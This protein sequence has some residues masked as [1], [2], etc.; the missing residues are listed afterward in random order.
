KPRGKLAPQSTYSGTF[1][2]GA[3]ARDGSAL[4]QEIT[5][6]FRTVDSLLVGQVFP[7]GGAEEVATDTAVTVIFNK[8]VVP[9]KIKEEQASLPQPLLFTPEVAG[10]GEWI[11]SSVYVFQP[12]TRLRSA[13]HYRVRV[14]QGLVDTTGIPMQGG[15]EWQFGTESPQV[16]AYSLVNGEQ[17]PT[18]LVRNVLLDQ[19]FEFT[20]SQPMDPESVGGAL[21]LA[22]R[23]T[24]KPVALKLSW[25][26]ER[27]LL[28][29]K[30]VQRLEIASF[31]DL[32]L[33]DTAAAED[34]G[35][36][37]EGKTIKL[38]TVPQP[39]IVGVS[40]GPDSTQDHFSALLSITFAS[41]MKLSSLAGRVQITP[42]PKSTN[43]Y[44]NE[45]DRQ[46][47]IYGLDPS[48]EYVVR[49]LP[50]MQDIYGNAIRTEYSFSFKTAR[51]DPSATMLLPYPAMVYREKGKQ[52]LYFQYT[53][54]TSLS[55]TVYSMSFEEFSGMLRADKARESFAPGSRKP[56]L[57]WRLEAPVEEN[58]FNRL[59]L[60][61]DEQGAHLSPG[62]YF[63]GLQAEPFQTEY[64]Y[65]QA[66]YFIVAS[67][68]I[69][70]KTTD[71]E[72]L[73][74]VVDL[75][76]GKP[77]PGEDVTFYDEKLRPLGS[78][79]TDGDGLAYLDKIAK[80]VYAQAGKAGR[81]AFAS[82][83]WGSGMSAGEF[84][85]WTGYYGPTSGSF[86]Y[87]YTDRPLYRPGQE[88]HFK[89]IL[90]LDDDLHYS[91]PTERP[92]QV[93]IT[94][95]E[96]EVY[97]KTLDVSE[98]GSFEDVF[99]IAE[100]A[101][102][103]SY[104][105]QVGYK[106]D[107]PFG[108]VSFRVAEYR[109]PQF[110]LTASAAAS[111]VLVGADIPFKLQADYY[112]G[113]SLGG[114]E[115]SWFTEAAPYSFQP[116]E[117]YWQFSFTDY[118]FD[119]YRSQAA[120][121]AGGLLDTGTGMTDETGAFSV[122]QPATLSKDNV[123]R[124]ITFYANVTDVAGNLVGGN[125]SVIVHQSRVYAGIRPVQYLGV[126]GK[127]LPFELVALDWSSNPQAGMTVNVDIMKEE[128]F[129]VQKQDKFGRL[130]WE[131]TLKESR[132]KRY[133]DVV[134]GADGLA[135]ISFVPPAGGQY[136]AIVTVRD[137]GGHSHRASVGV[138]VASAEYIPWRQT[139]DR[140]FDLVTDKES[141]SPGE[142]AQVLIASPFEGEV[143]ALISYERGHIYERKVVLL[144]ENSTIYELP[145]T[146][147]MAPGVYL[148]V[149]VVRGAGDGR[150]DFKT[151]VTQLK[152]DTSQQALTVKV[153][154]DAQTAQPQGKVTY[155][156]QTSDASGKPVQAEVSLALVDK[157]VLALAPAN[158]GP[159]L[160]AF[161]RHRALAVA[162][163]V[164]IVLDAESFNAA[165]EAPADGQ[166][167]GS[168]G[169]GKG[170]GDLGVIDV[171]QEFKD[172]A[173]WR[174]VL[175]TGPEGSAQ[176]T[177]ELPDNLTTWQMDARAATLDSRFGQATSELVS[178]KPLFV[179]L[180]APRFFVVRDAARVGATIHNNTDAPQRVSV[181]LDA[182][183]VQ[184][185]SEGTQ[186]LEVGA[187]QQAYVTWDLVVKP[188]ASRVDLL[189]QASAGK[190]Q[191]STRPTLG[192]LPG[193]GI[194][195]HAYH[196]RETVGTA[197]ILQE[198]GSITE[199]VQL[200][201]AL[202]GSDA[203]LSVDLSPSLAASMV[204]GLTYLEDYP[205][206]CIEQTISRFL[207][208]VIASR[209]L[210]LAGQP[211]PLGE[212]LE[213][214]IAQALQRINASQNADG[215]WGWWGEQ[216]SHPL[217]T[218]YVVLGLVEAQKAGHPVSLQVLERGVE[219]LLKNVPALHDNSAWYE[220][221]QEAFIVYVLAR[222]G[223]SMDQQAAMLFQHKDALSIYG[224]AYLAH[225]IFIKDGQD[226]RLPALLA[227]I[228]G[229]A[230]L[231]A[232]GVH[233]QEKDV[234][235]W[236]WNTDTRTTA[237]VLNMLTEVDPKS[238]LTA[239]AVR[240]LMAHRESAHWAS[241]QETAWVLM[242]LTNWLSVS[243]EFETDYQYA[244]GLNG[245]LLKQGSASR[246]NL[247]EAV[248]VRQALSE[249]AN[250]LVFTRGEGKGN[251]YYSAYLDV[252]LPV[253][254]VHALDQ[255]ILLSRQYYALDDL[256][257]PVTSIQKGELVQARVTIVVPESLH[258]VVV[259]DPLPAGLEAVD[260]SL[261]TGAQVPDKYSRDD[262]VRKGWGWWYFSHV[263]IR[264]E[265]VELSAD[266]LPAGTYVFTYLARA[267][268]VGT[269]QVIPV[270]AEE[271]YFPDV[272]GRG[273][274]SVF[275]VKP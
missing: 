239:N 173:Y 112:S 129:S 33:T 103:G 107:E 71:T 80:P 104:D 35:R 83:E 209:A 66:A 275:T 183:G 46:Y 97:N 53:N 234:D 245:D 62:Y 133:P 76:T 172:T 51:L 261:L 131:S 121:P 75:E 189:A 135:R 7:A 139:N 238:P 137:Q 228:S 26:D 101:Q 240:W 60:N 244:V 43:T 231:S 232:A 270:S 212:D 74:W 271:F 45:Y 248:S 124:R 153:T 57:E 23:E 162:T 249:A 64:R 138:W 70:L 154:P 242:A 219:F 180:Q 237:I 21:S 89:G 253:D 141:Y 3:A 88:V 226:K 190:Y 269:F 151:G 230:A 36:L 8:P 13:Q 92:V 110:Q 247:T 44:Y 159:I 199:T 217:T 65:L 132:V 202:E 117:D 204:G 200:P 99:Q 150:P 181:S 82:R 47:N 15:F 241:T 177:V 251:L 274:G 30:P 102:V 206:L 14:R 98:T 84:G 265:K 185:K 119:W 96:E 201:E 143:Y 87:V 268:T 211:N 272:A 236:N 225:A 198:A 40:P 205:Y 58:K 72:A 16:L 254:Q 243:G 267:S 94:S 49:V 39:A 229:A 86:A 210:K 136:K 85:V 27:T 264:D 164:G 56:V 134:L 10:Q 118:G 175:E 67:D 207:P 109:K 9:L 91:L 12:E 41:P 163:A 59:K 11:N 160:E 1:G 122:T 158:T 193:Q 29:V 203:Q 6:E 111:D 5:L 123:S 25:N 214:N 127:E 73:A 263:G 227:D 258:Y 165:Y 113:G 235:Y 213:N 144:K 78:V 262:L 215:G 32:V 182:Q 266:Y 221:N 106:P 93:R 256:K 48:T 255:G 174:G 188:D 148:S 54:V 195:V 156:V 157:A 218:A 171:R 170:A 95:M 63:I 233:W 184:L 17:N 155:T 152:V 128:W 81:V 179:E 257:T 37:R 167:S 259:D 220:F 42:K 24:R 187:G 126:E 149:V 115:V 34:G 130:S 146:K 55:L 208:N 18:A 176:V 120:Q 69:T 216:K 116:S 20:F 196:V 166:Q 222:A 19:A 168:G 252:S 169:G 4:A 125:A 38:S 61:F 90:R 186:E 31:Y 223:R 105:L 161:Y 178:T 192:T 52:E 197:G 108:F 79:K 145:I 191:D 100:D 68:N 250:Y 246:E 77:Q 114:A 28:N 224:K 273:D 2:T 260:S 22:N 50:G 140:S 194:P 142:T 147:D